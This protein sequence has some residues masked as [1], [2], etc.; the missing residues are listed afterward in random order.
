MGFQ[1]SE[2]LPEEWEVVEGVAR[3]I[4]T[5]P[6]TRIVIFQTKQPET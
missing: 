6:Q 2:V 3:L 1:Q 5:N 4:R